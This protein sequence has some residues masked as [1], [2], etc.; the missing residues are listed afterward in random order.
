M[1]KRKLQHS[2]P[3]YAQAPLTFSSGQA[4]GWSH[5]GQQ[6]GL[7]VPNF[8][9]QGVAGP[10]RSHPVPQ[11][12]YQSQQQAGYNQQMGHQQAAPNSLP[13]GYHHQRPQS[14]PAP[15]PYI[16]PRQSGY[17]IPSA[18]RPPP[19]QSYPL[20]AAHHPQ[21]QPGPPGKRQRMN[22]PPIR[23]PP[24]MLAAAPGHPHPASSQ[25]LPSSY[26]GG[27][28]VAQLGPQ[29]GPAPPAF[30]RP[31]SQ[32]ASA[33]QQPTQ[34]HHRQRPATAATG[35]QAS[36]RSQL[37]NDLLEFAAQA[38]PSLVRAGSPRPVFTA[39]AWQHCPERPAGLSLQ[40]H[41]KI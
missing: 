19:P 33:E 4:H 24:P 9:F 2:A 1:S 37:H 38:A 35:A 11:T 34:L 39:I 21:I 14:Q 6:L 20:E 30:P 17:E 27:H 23:L 15:E 18:H 5:P 36:P 32:A 12:Q 7:G 13:F 22:G 26:F 10:V 31:S 29:A 3:G 40:M 16:P 28:L 41:S 25:Q 8:A